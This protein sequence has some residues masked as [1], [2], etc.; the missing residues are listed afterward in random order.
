MDALHPEDRLESLDRAQC[1][2]L[3]ATEEVGRLAF[4][5]DGRPRI[6]PV[7]FRVVDGEIVFISRPGAKLDAV[8]HQ[9]PVA[10]EVDSIEGWA[11][12][13]WSVL[14]QG[15]ASVV[16][17]GEQVAALGSRLPQPWAPADP[18]SLVRIIPDGLSGRRVRLE[19][20][21]VTVVHQT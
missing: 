19:P 3:L 11:H 21:G 17:D 12:A 16:S 15:V 5:I 18:H 7:N 10:F 6:T 8:I 20:G 4:Q 13:G 2:E 14:V 9:Q 1:L